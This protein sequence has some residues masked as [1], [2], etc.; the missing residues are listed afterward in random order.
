MNEFC[1]AAVSVILSHNES[2]SNVTVLIINEIQ[3]NSI[4]G[5]NRFG[6]NF[7]N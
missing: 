5:S 1:I 4:P 7:V 3:R 6:K 2:I